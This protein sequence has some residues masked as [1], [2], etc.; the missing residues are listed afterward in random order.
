VF[1]IAHVGPPLLVLA[2]IAGS[3]DNGQLVLGLGVGS[4]VAAGLVGLIAALVGPAG[5]GGRSIG[6]LFVV[7]AVVVEIL[8]LV[9]GATWTT[10]GVIA[11]IS[12][13]FLA[14]F[15]SWATSSAFAPRAYWGLVVLAMCVSG[16]LLLS[17]R[18]P[19]IVGLDLVSLYSLPALG[20]AV[21]TVLV[22]GVTAAL[23]RSAKRGRANAAR[24]T[25]VRLPRVPGALA[26]FW[27]SVAAWTTGFLGSYL[28][29]LVWFGPLIASLGSMGLAI[30]AVIL[31]H[32]ARG[33]IRRGEGGG[34]GLTIA[35]LVIGYLFLGLVVLTLGASGVALLLSAG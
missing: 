30:G 23:D 32:R 28:A 29:V 21:L 27:L 24:G 7:A 26:G 25:T 15:L 19:L 9:F 33:A 6:A 14:W 31:A 1:L 20:F 22:V 13:A 18:L 8:Y 17:I 35:A 4:L 10:A 34:S 5:G 12:G 2:M 16:Y 11:A 3:F